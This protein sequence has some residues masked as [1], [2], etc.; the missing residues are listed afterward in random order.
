MSLLH[1]IRFWL[2]VCVRGDY[3]RHC[4]NVMMTHTHTH[5]HLGTACGNVHNTSNISPPLI[6]RLNIQCPIQ[7]DTHLF[8]D[9]VKASSSAEKWAEQEWVIV[10]MMHYPVSPHAVIDYLWD[11]CWRLELRVI[12]FCVGILCLLLPN[13]VFIVAN[14]S[15]L[16]G[17]LTCYSVTVLPELYRNS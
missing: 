15:N 6:L 7:A 1:K 2:N 17:D 16:S 4:N 10:S 9:K 8:S 12:R 13:V 3:P 14:K 5:T 11:G